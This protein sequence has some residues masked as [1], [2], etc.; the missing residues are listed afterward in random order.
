MRIAFLNI[1]NGLV[2]RGSEIFVSEMARCLSN[3]HDIT[4]FQLGKPSHQTYKEIQIKN[5]PVISYQQK[6]KKI[7]VLRFIKEQMYHLS[8]LLFTLMCLFRMRKKK[9]DWIIPVN[10]RFQTVMCR[11]YRFVSG[12]KILISGHAGVGFEDR[13][14]LVLGKPEIFVALS[15]KAYQWARTISQSSKIIYIPNGVDTQKFNPA[16]LPVKINL[17]APIILCVSAL[18]PYKRINLLI[19]AVSLCK[20]GSLLLIG[21]GELNKEISKLGKEKLGDR[22]LHIVSVSHKDMPR[23]Y[24]ASKIFSL[25]SKESE[26]F[27][28]VYLE[29]LASN[30]PIVAPDDEIRRAIIKDSGLFCNVEIVRE[31]ART[32]DKALSM[33]F[34]DNPRKQAEKFSWDFIAE[35]Y[36]KNLLLLKND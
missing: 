3:G 13:L 22:F 11:I 10:G 27:G 1:Y 31:Y 30:I 2:E 17:P 16:V 15:L 25:P 9:Y 36:E 4:V 18:L 26:A 24:N 33:D 32:L 21:D 14:N 19:D 12:T 7:F 23:Y 35:Q 20:E 29:A 34:G 5:I 6:G 28:L 8:V